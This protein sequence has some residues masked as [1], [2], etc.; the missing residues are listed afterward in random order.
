MLPVFYLLLLL[1]AACVVLLMPA[2]WLREI[3]LQYR[4]PR[5]VECPETHRQ[6]AVRFDALRAAMRG[7]GGTPSLRLSDCTRWPERGD[8]GQ[9]CI[10][11]A[12]RHHAFTEGEVARP[13]T[14]QLYHLPVLIAAWVAWLLGVGWH[15]EYFFR[16]PWRTGLHIDPRAWIDVTEWLSPHLLS[17][18]MSLLFA[19][20]VAAVL[21]RTHQRGTWHGM[22]IAAVLWLAMGIAVLLTTGVAGIP[23]V[24]LQSELVF[25]LISSV[26]IGAIVGGLEG[27]MVL[28]ST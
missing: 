20:G 24:L 17:V 14:K 19:Y 26:V 8:C 9:E 23:L 21:M 16:E 22:L 5:A 2:I 11:E 13:R 27:R 10:P 18:G 1:L 15:S 7:L 12:L 25:T 3:F 4:D 28:Q 6:V